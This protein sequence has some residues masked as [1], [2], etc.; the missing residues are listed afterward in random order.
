MV[1]LERATPKRLLRRAAEGW[2]AEEG[3]AHLDATLGFFF[4]RKLFQPNARAR[5]KTYEATPQRVA[6]ELG[7]ADVRNVEAAIGRLEVDGYIA[8]ERHPRTPQR[9]VFRWDYAA[10]GRRGNY[11]MLT[12]AELD[13]LVFSKRSQQRALALILDRTAG[14]EVDAATVPL[15]RFHGSRGTVRAALAELEACGLIEVEPGDALHANRYHRTRRG[16]TSTDRLRRRAELVQRAEVGPRKRG[17]PRKNPDLDR[18]TS[19]TWIEPRSVPGSNHIEER[20]TSSETQQQHRGVVAPRVSRSTAAPAL[21]PEAGRIW[22]KVRAAGVKG[23]LPAEAAPKIQAEGL[24][25]LL[26]AYIAKAATTGNPGGY[27]AGFLRS[28]LESDPWP[29]PRGRPAESRPAYLD[30]VFTLDEEVA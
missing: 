26:D 24:E 13:A 28:V 4:A 12:D 18:T 9:W 16:A 20:D 19:A 30:R 3:S 8:R 21:T 11:A 17:R 10:D 15:S 5:N 7:R 6:A 14:A 25:P 2:D 1:A 22:A 23:R 27:L 29:M